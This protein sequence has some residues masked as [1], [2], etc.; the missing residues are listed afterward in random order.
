ADWA[1]GQRLHDELLPLASGIMSLA[2]NPIGVKT[3]LELLG[4]DSG[5]MRL[6]LTPATAEV[7]ATCRMLLESMGLPV[8]QPT[9][10]AV[11]AGR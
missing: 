1:W 3:A 4:R 10:P 7:R 9:S 2:T 5:A 8:G 11:G 6:P